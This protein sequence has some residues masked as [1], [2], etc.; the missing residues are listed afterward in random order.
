M[1]NVNLA[2]DSQCLTVTL[3]GP[4]KIMK[5]EYDKIM[6]FWKFYKMII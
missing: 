1:I 4:D 2:R 6:N 5:N 3:T